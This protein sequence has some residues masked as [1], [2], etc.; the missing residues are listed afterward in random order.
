M[1]LAAALGAAVMGAAAPLVALW[2]KRL[3]PVT[4][5]QLRQL[6]PRLSA[7]RARQLLPGLNQ[8][9]RDADLRTVRRRAAFMA[10]V[11]V[12]SDGLTALEEY[13]SGEAYEGRANL[14]NTQ[15]GDGVRFKGR[16]WMQATGR[17][18]YTAA[19]A[20]LGLPLVA[21][22][23]LLATVTG[24]WRFASYYWRTRKLNRWADLGT[25]EGFR[26]ITYRI[27]GG[28]NGAATREAE[29]ARALAILGATQ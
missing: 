10:Q 11:L 14:G 1:I 25:L 27:N 9:A 16:G 19:A 29:W 7:D 23:E 15:P 28:Q 12:E 3:P 5:A 8:A 2:A 17:A 22:P 13:A 6:A 24:G 18:N 20:A 21:R 26:A 4:L